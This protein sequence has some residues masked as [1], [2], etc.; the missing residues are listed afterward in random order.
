MYYG[1]IAEVWHGFFTRETPKGR[2]IA[3]VQTY[4]RYRIACI[5]YLQYTICYYYKHAYNTSS[6]LE[7]SHRNDAGLTPSN[8]LQ[9]AAVNDSEYQREAPTW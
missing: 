6:I 3:T 8:L 2:R 7:Y 5:A 4:P 1:D 9:L